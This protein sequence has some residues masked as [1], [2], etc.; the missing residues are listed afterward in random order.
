MCVC[1]MIYVYVGSRVTCL[2]AY[3]SRAFVF[4]FILNHNLGLRSTP[5][6]KHAKPCL[7]KKLEERGMQVS[8]GEPGCFCKPYYSARL[9]LY[10][11]RGQ[12]VKTRPH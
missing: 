1:F 3:T 7:G 12:P 10:R 8:G 6:G 11:G 9:A 2:P 4:T 5:P